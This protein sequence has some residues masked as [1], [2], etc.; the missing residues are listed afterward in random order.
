MNRETT[1]TVICPN[2]R[3]P[4][5]LTEALTHRLREEM[6]RELTVGKAALEDRRRTVEAE[7]AKQ[8]L[9]LDAQAA[10]LERERAAV[11]GRVAE[12][13]AAE[14]GVIE[15][16]ARSEAAQAQT[17]ARAHLEER[18]AAETAEKE[19]AQQEALRGLQAKAAYEA[20]L[21]QVE[22][23]VQREVEKSRAAIVEAAKADAAAQSERREREYAQ[24]MESL[25]KQLADAQRKAEQG[26]QQTQGEAFEVS[27]ADALGGAFPAD[28][29]DDVP[30]GIKGADLVQTV[31]SPHHRDC[32][33]IV[34][35]LKATK[36]WSGKWIAKLKDDQRALTAEVA[37]LVSAVLPEGVELIAH[38]D[39]VWVCAP[40]AA[41]GVAAMLRAGLIQVS[42]ARVVEEGKAGKAD[43]LYR[44]LTSPAFTQ[45]LEAVVESFSQMRIDLDKERRAFTAAWAKREQQIQRALEG[46]TGL[47]GDMQGLLG[48]SLPAVEQLE[49]PGIELGDG[50][51]TDA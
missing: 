18:L 5:P 50:S 10:L 47:Y 38:V 13:V 51:G 4:I 37:V 48:R 28:R 46:A 36:A 40:R 31:R 34:W 11:A 30:K 12:Q 20:K 7:I 17:V 35:E 2:C 39:G 26:S 43:V 42:T 9:T 25:R 22:L 15:A 23:D 49:L 14:R 41:L 32:G 3:E 33:A 1:D 8:R 21:K 16:R 19:H 44:Y 6:E 24:Q 45:R 27:L 29:V